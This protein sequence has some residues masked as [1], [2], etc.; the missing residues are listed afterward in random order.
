MGLPPVCLGS[1]VLLG[2]AGNINLFSAIPVIGPDLSTWIRGDFN[3]SDVTLNRFFA[4]HVTAV[5]LVLLRFWLWLTSSPCTKWVL[6]TLMALES[7]KTKTKTVF[8]AMV[9]HS[10]LTT[11][12]KNILGC[13]CIP[14]CLL[15]CV[16]LCT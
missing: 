1:N 16:V 11:L 13:C 2:C 15:F 3:V 10:I 4:L 5:P 8:H 6:T 7:R 12:L 9:S 14:D